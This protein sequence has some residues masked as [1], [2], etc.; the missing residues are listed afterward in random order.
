[1]FDLT[2]IMF[3]TIMMLL[4]V[5]RAIY[6]DSTRPWFERPGQNTMKPKADQT[7]LRPWQRPR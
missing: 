5:V 4:V 2:G 1:M 7:N 6:L 3:S